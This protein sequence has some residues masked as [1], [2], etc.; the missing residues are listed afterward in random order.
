MATRYDGGPLDKIWDCML[1]QYFAVA[2]A[3][4]NV[5]SIIAACAGPVALG[6]FIKLDIQRGWVNFYVR[7]QTSNYPRKVAD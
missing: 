7:I 6:G 1:T 4:I 2:Q 3:A 5:A